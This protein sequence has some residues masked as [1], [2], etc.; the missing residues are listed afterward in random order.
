[1]SVINITNQ[2]FHE[3]VVKQQQDGTVGFLG[4]LVR[5][6]LYAFAGDR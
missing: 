5:S 3:E 2:N 1:M 4:R 6:L